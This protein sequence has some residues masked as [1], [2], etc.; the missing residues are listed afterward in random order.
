[1]TVLA[2]RHQWCQ[3]SGPDNETGSL[4]IGKAADVIAIDLSH[5]KPSRYIARFRR[6]STPP[7]DHATDVWVAGKRLLKQRHLTTV[8][9][10]DL[11][12]KSP[13][14]S[15]VYPANPTKYLRQ[16]QQMTNNLLTLAMCPS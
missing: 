2:R 4:S 10:E 3:G 13:N 6:L 11:R 14:G 1:M 9:I 8:N 15:S 7:A 12:V 5:L 16:A